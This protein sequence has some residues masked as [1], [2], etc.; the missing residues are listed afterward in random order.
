MKLIWVEF[1]YLGGTQR[2][3]KSDLGYTEGYNFNFGVSKYQ[4]LDNPCFKAYLPILSNI[5]IS[6]FPY[7]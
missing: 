2:G 5:V 3:Y 4:K 6:K 7:F 1:F